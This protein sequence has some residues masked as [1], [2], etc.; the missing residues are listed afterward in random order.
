MKFIFPSHV[1]PSDPVA[2][3]D[4]GSRTAGQLMADSDRLA[5]SIRAKLAEIHADASAAKPE[6]L[7]ICADRYHFAV[8]L[9]AAWKAGAIAALP[10][11]G[12]EATVHAL[13][14]RPDIHLI[15]HDT[16]R[17]T[18][19]NPALDLRQAIGEGGE[20]GASDSSGANYHPMILDEREMVVT[21]YT[22]G[23]TGEHKRCPKAAA[24][25]L[26]EAASHVA[27]FNLQ[28]GE[29]FAATVPGH[30][31]YGLIW[32]VLVPL[33]S[34]GVLDRKTTLFPDAVAAHARE[35]GA[36][37][38]VSVPA[39]LRTLAELDAMPPLKR[40]TSSSAPLPPETAQ[41]LFDKFGLRVTEIF[42][43]SETGGIAFREEPGAPHRPLSG[44]KVT[45]GEEG[46]LML[47][48][49]FLPLD[50]PRPLPCDDRI[51]ILPDGRFILKG[52]L[53]GV[54]KVGGKRVALAEVERRILAMPGVKDAAVTAET[55]DSGRGAEL[56][57]AVVGQVTKADV[58]DELKKWL[59]PVALPRRIL[60]VDALPREE[61]GKLK[62]ANMKALF[63]AKDD[64]A[65]TSSAASPAAS[66]APEK[67][68]FRD[69]EVVRRLQ[70]AFADKPVELVPSKEERLE[71]KDG[72]RLT[73]PVPT[74]YYY[75]RGHF[76]GLPI[77]PGVVQL[78]FIVRRQI[79]RLWPDLNRGASKIIQLK[80]KKTIPPGTVLVLTLDRMAGTDKVN[81]D[82]TDGTDSCSQ[83]RFVF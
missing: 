26:G 7:V 69:A 40:I 25:I 81:F 65:A 73:I 72:W 56:W 8:A 76:D 70:S 60:F 35:I 14:A 55:V 17:D 5:T 75:F 16:D 18:A 28:P 30:H 12:Q 42:G 52:R 83:G 32:S 21:L 80:F 33:M 62:K 2:V 3:G 63:A 58:R 34:G 13:A 53:D 50:I 43:S 71:G 9:M 41:K 19:G 82:L 39:H 20:S 22:S 78:D 47:D 11:N 23:S 29:V 74:D 77:L 68:T 59:D 37:Y 61:N 24:E 48:S 38:L 66:A 54:V 15:V 4:P 36:T 46:R 49:P 31:V 10:P 79:A 67:K 1:R 57:A 64:G 44:V 51:E 27:S 6:V 45:C